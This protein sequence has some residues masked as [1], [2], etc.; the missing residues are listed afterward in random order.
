[1]WDKQTI[2]SVGKT[3]STGFDVA[4]FSIMKSLRWVCSEIVCLLRLASSGLLMI[5]G[6]NQTLS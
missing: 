6:L 2:C 4:L 5:C 1:M 3:A